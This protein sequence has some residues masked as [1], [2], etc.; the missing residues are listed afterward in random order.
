MIAK[1]DNR[2]ANHGDTALDA[3]YNLPQGQ[4]GVKPSAWPVVLD[5]KES[6]L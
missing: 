2:E 1:A 6:P 4:P 3:G 5:D